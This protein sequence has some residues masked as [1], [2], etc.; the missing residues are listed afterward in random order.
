M[1]TLCGSDGLREMVQQVGEPHADW[2]LGASPCAWKMS[3]FCTALACDG[4]CDDALLARVQAAT[5]GRVIQ[6]AA[7]APGPTA[8]VGP[9]LD[10]DG[11][12]FVA[13]PDELMDD[14][15]IQDEA[16]AFD[17]YA[18][19]ILPDAR[20]ELAG[21]AG[22]RD[23]RASAVLRAI[24]ALWE[25]EGQCDDE[26]D[27]FDSRAASLLP[28]LRAELGR[29]AS[30]RHPHAA[31]VQKALDELA[32]LEGQRET[33]KRGRP[34]PHASGFDDDDDDAA[35]DAA[36]ASLSISENAPRARRPDAG[37]MEEAA[38]TTRRELDWNDL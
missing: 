2:L 31:I 30:L 19:A 7:P 4:A 20:G 24:A 38:D 27:E 12:L 25:L 18:A 33:R 1:D 26:R 23:S 17:D 21:L 29:L 5:S 37:S 11:P 32:G 6:A 3:D 13:N 36:L 22:L 15:S 8:V 14:A 9:S 10:G 34:E 16:E 35:P 28:G